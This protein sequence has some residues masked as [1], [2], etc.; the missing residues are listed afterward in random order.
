M[1]RKINL[2]YLNSLPFETMVKQGRLWEIQ[3][4]NIEN[5]TSKCFNIFYGSKVNRKEYLKSKSTIVY[6]IKNPILKKKIFLIKITILIYHFLCL[7]ILIGKICRLNKIHIIIS[8]S[9]ALRQLEVSALLISRIYNIPIIGYIGRNFMVFKFPHTI[10]EKII[11]SL[12]Y[13]ILR[14][15]SK[16]IMRPKSEKFLSDYYKIKKSKIVTIPHITRF[17]NFKDHS[18]IPAKLLKWMT[19]KEIILYYGRLERDKLVDDII[20][21]FKMVR[22][23]RDNAYLLIIGSGNDKKLL[24]ELASDLGIDGYIRWENPMHQE[25]LGPVSFS[26]EV[27]VHPTGGKGL[28]ESAVMAKPVITYKSNSYDYGLIEDIKPAYRNYEQ[29]AKCI[30][31]YLSNP[32]LCAEHGNALKKRAIS[33]CDINSVQK[34]LTTVIDNLVINT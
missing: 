21:A 31:K 18:K 10:K 1:D 3:V 24:K 6:C 14:L 15:A 22:K 11:Y 20:K 7:T 19:S 30:L 26:S 9:N 4:R 8:N 2:L 34:K 25:R 32:A 23:F 33:H 16:V 28:L 13:I 12:E 5:F 27:H 29:L 17:Q